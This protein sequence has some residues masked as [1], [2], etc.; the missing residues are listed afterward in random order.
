MKGDERRSERK[1]LCYYLR[2]IDTKT[3]KEL[4]RI[5]DI[6]PE[7]LMLL[8]D[9]P[10]QQTKPY[11]IRIL[12]DRKLFDAGLGNLDVDV[13]VRWSKPDANPSL[14]LT[15]LLF[16]DLDEKGK[17]IVK[18]LAKKISMKQGLDSEEEEVEYGAEEV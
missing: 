9:K 14:T 8:S 17:Q 15:G 1:V 4:G 2:V 6:T 5:A 7:G 12:L 18:N 11:S 16:L 13:N 10:L 3:G